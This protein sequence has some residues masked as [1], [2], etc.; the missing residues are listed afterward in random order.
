MQRTYYCHSN[1]A[2]IDVYW[3]NTNKGRMKAATISRLA[4]Q[5]NGDEQGSVCMNATHADD[6]LAFH[7]PDYPCNSTMNTASA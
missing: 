2:R 1:A 4:K 5:S 3:G 6:A 7:V